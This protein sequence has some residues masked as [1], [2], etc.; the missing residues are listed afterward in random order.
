RLVNASE[1][2]A[3]IATFVDEVA[4]STTN[5]EPIAEGTLSSQRMKFAAE[6]LEEAGNELQGKEKEKP[7]GRAFLKGM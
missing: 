6:K 4:K 7:K 1:Q 5:P 3:V 2:L